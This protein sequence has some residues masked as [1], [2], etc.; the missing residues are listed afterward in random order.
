MPCIRSPAIQREGVRP[1]AES[2]ALAGSGALA[3]CSGMQTKPSGGREIPRCARNDSTLLRSGKVYF[4]TRSVVIQNGGEAE[5]KK[6]HPLEFTSARRNK[7]P[8]LWV[9][10]PFSRRNAGDS[11]RPVPH[12]LCFCIQAGSP[13]DAGCGHFPRQRAPRIGQAFSP[14]VQATIPIK[15]ICI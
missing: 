6:L 14:T 3:I 5:V 12:N 4:N 8:L 1:N 11:A 10:T 7:D 2:N 13:S 9:L 15:I